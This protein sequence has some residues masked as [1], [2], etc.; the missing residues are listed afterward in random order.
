MAMIKKLRLYFDTEFTE[1]SKKG[2]LISLAFIS[3]NDEIFYAEFDDFSIETCNEWV[4]ENVISKL[5]FKNRE[6]F[7]KCSGIAKRIKKIR[8][9]QKNGQS[10]KNGEN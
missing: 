4:M 1:L 7:I 9:D 10:K 3:E 2:E 5:L 8:V 6:T